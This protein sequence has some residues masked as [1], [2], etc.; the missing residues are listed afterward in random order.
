MLEAA[1]TDS[2][3]WL[4]AQVVKDV[5]VLF[6]I[7]NNAIPT[8]M[9]LPQLYAVNALMDS[10]VAMVPVSHVL[11]YLI[12]SPVLLVMPAFVVLE[13]LGLIMVSASLDLSVLLVTVTLVYQ[14]MQQIAK[15]VILALLLLLMV[16][17][18]WMHA[19]LVL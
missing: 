14:E 9:M 18:N 4:A 7:A 11:H 2:L 8:L 19:R 13:I 12:A 5:A 15:G 17:V 6:L 10:S 1:A 3:D 16:H